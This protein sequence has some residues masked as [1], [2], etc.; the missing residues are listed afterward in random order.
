MLLDL[1]EKK[2]NNA[3]IIQQMYFRANH[4]P[5]TVLGDK[6]TAIN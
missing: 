1:E 6:D 3:F 2:F 5:S 4:T